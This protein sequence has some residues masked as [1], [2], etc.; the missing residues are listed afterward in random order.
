MLLHSPIQVDRLTIPIRN[1][2]DRLQGLK[3]VQ[4]SDFHYDGRFLREDLMTRSLPPTK[5][6]PI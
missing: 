3:I 5:P 1:L 2:P 4:M 6:R